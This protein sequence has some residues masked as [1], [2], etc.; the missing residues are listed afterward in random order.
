MCKR[1]G[2]VEGWRGDYEVPCVRG[3]E[4]WLLGAM[5]KRGGGVVI[6]CHV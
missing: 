1:G 6:R 4:G 2:G 5:C 3:V